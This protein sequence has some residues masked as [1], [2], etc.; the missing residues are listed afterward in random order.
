MTQ[1]EQEASSI[2]YSCG[3]KL[4]LL[5]SGNYALFKE[6]EHGG[7][8]TE[9]L[10]GVLPIPVQVFAALDAER[11]RHKRYWAE[12]EARQARGFAEPAGSVTDKTVEDLGL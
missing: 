9:I 2:R 11:E 12:Y 8:E 5:T 7:F 1:D 3:V 6:L 4:A 10:P